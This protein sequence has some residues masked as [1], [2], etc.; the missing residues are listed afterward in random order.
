MFRGTTFVV[1]HADR[2]L[3]DPR[4]GGAQLCVPYGSFAASFSYGLT[5][6]PFTG[7][8]PGGINDGHQGRESS[9][10]KLGG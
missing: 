8:A 5:A 2:S 1:V 7:R 6:L 9:V 3:I 4:A 10:A